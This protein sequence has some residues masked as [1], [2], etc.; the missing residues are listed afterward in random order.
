M[1]ENH[2]NATEKKYCLAMYDVRGKQAFIFRN[3]HIKEIVGGSCII[4]DCFKNVLFPAAVEY[5]NRCLAEEGKPVSDESAIYTYGIGEPFSAEAFKTRMESE[6]WIA[7]VIYDGGGNFLVMYKTYQDFVEVNKIFTRRLLANY[8]GLNVLCTG[9]EV[10]GKL[11]N[12]KEDS[13]RLY[14]KHGLM[15]KADTG[16]RPVNTLPFV[17]VDADTSLPLS[18]MRYTGGSLKVKVSKESAAKY[19]AY[20]KESRAQGSARDYGE[21]LLDEI[22]VK[23]GVDSNLAVVF[24]D[25]NNMGAQVEACLD[26]KT[27]YEECIQAL[28]QF[29]QKIQKEYVDDRLNA[30]DKA[31]IAEYG[32]EERRKR[33]RLV[34]H[35]GDE[36]SFICRAKDALM[37]VKEY[38]KDLPESN[39]S[40]AGIAIFNSHA[41]YAAA[42]RI[43]EECCEN[44][45][46]RMKEQGET[47]TCY[48]DY[49]YCQGGI[50]MDLEDI[51][52]RETGILISKPWLIR[53]NAKG[54]PTCLETIEKAADALN[55][56]GS[57][58]NIKGLAMAAKS[59]LSDLDMEMARI[60]AH[61]KAEVQ[62]RIRGLFK[63]LNGEERRNMIYDIVIAYDLW[64]RKEIQKETEK[65]E[66][67]GV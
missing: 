37:L 41:P 65:G 14:A 8:G 16:I 42:Y 24:I 5:R 60:Y 46:K 40:C 29:S 55:E 54:S 51:R 67:S 62:E 38:F 27:T 10:D 6:N 9:I 11:S 4:R 53:G 18:D 35:A 52:K 59:S 45:K 34:V 15:E 7:E 47:N 66:E 48:V 28:R 61:Q 63:D 32:E 57:R 19:D 17:Q 13:R 56:I 21:K 44:G 39:S 31:L 43:A 50:G 58:T 23:K 1:S 12:Y 25:G 3:N 49:H 20:E 26:G 64:F 33:H 22:I 30:I 36:M 2:P